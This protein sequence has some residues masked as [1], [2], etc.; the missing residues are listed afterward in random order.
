MPSRA[1]N[2]TM[3]RFIKTVMV[4]TTQPMPQ[5]N[6]I[7]SGTMW[8]MIQLPQKR[9]TMKKANAPVSTIDAVRSVIQPWPVTKLMK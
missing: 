6:S 1:T 4:H 5:M 3:P 9:P 2:E 7:R 8:R